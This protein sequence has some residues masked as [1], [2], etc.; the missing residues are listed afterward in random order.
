M[1]T[2]YLPAIFPGFDKH[3]WR[4]WETIMSSR[5]MS[6]AHRRRIIGTWVL[7]L[8]LGNR[9]SARR[10]PW[11]HL[12]WSSMSSS[13]SCRRNFPWISHKNRTSHH[14]RVLPPS[15]HFSPAHN[16]VNSLR[17]CCVNAWDI[18]TGAPFTI[19]VS[20]AVSLS[21]P[22]WMDSEHVEANIWKPKGRPGL[23][24]TSIT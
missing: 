7:F 8:F 11:D 4:I 13:S 19:F 18:I 21:H 22:T 10:G 3:D 15:R 12:E 6:M 5:F 17:K 20:A 2:S 24:K 9:F 1:T 14:G 16:T 23:Y